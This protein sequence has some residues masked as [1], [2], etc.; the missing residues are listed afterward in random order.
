MHSLI[1]EHKKILLPLK[2]RHGSKELLVKLDN[3]FKMFLKLLLL[4]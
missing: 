3:L 1:F 4:V 2:R